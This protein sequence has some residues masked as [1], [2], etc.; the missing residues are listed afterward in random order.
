MTWSEI[1]GHYPHQ[2]LMVEALQARSEL[3]KRH[4]EKLAVVDAFADGEAALRAYLTLHRAAPEREL[5][6]VHSDREMLDIAE[7]AWLGLRTAG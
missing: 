1:R 5:Y 3:G 2:W 6:V 7:Q 4:L